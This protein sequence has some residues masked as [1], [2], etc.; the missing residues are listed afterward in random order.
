MSLICAALTWLRNHKRETFD[1]SVEEAAKGFGEEPDW[2]VQQMLKRKREELT[3]A[4]TEREARLESI[5]AREKV[6]ELRGAKRRKV[7]E[8]MDGQQLERANEDEWLLADNT[9]A[10]DDAANPSGFSKETQALM[11]KLG[12]GPLKGQDNEEAADTNE[13]K[14]RF[15]VSN[16]SHLSSDVLS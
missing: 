2:I 6:F 1:V 8:G 7:Q 13:I 11:A 12:M 16:S 14:V 5:R 9:A 10:A 15:I 3:S 4:W